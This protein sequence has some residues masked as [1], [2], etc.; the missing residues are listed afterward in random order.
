MRLYWKISFFVLIFCITN[1]NLTEKQNKETYK[2]NPQFEL[3]EKI[4]FKLDGRQN[5]YQNAILNNWLLGLP[6]RNPYMLNMFEERN[7]QKNYNLLPWSGE[8]AGKYLTGA[9][10]I[11][12]LTQSNELKKEL[13]SLVNRLGVLQTT[14]GYLGPW[15]K[16][17]ELTGR[18]PADDTKQSKSKHFKNTWDSWNHYHLM[19]GLL[20]YNRLF[21]DE[22]S[23]E[24]CRKIGDRLCTEF[25]DQPDNLIQTEK[26][27]WGYGNMEFNLTAAHALCIL[28][29]TVGDNKYLKLAK[30]MVDE[31]FLRYGDYVNRAMEGKNFFETEW[32]DG[33]RWERL[34]AIMA[35]AEL[36]W[37]TGDKTY[38]KA[39]EQ[40]W[41]SIAEHDIHNTGAFSTHE[42]ATGN[43]YEDGP[44][45]TCCTVAWQALS[46]EMLKMTGNS[47][48]ADMLEL[49][50]FN[51]AYG[52]WDISGSWN[53][54]HT[55]SF[56]KRVPSTVD[57]AFQIRKGTEE[58]NCCSA[59]AP[60]SIGILADWALM[61]NGRGFILNWYGKGEINV[62]A[63]KI[64][65]KFIQNTDYPKDGNIMI[66]VDPKKKVF[67]SLQLR[68]PFWSR[69]NK[70]IV[71]GEEIS[72][73]SSGSYLKLDRTWNPGDKI[74]V[75]L[76][77][78][79]HFWPGENQ[80]KG[81]GSVYHGPILLAWKKPDEPDIKEVSEWDDRNQPVISFQS[82]KVGSKLIGE[83]E[84]ERLSLIFDQYPDGGQSQV[85]IDDE[86]Y[87]VIDHF[88]PQVKFLQEWKSPKLKSGKHKFRIKILPDKNLKSKDNWVRLREIRLNS[89]PIVDACTFQPKVAS[90]NPKRV[91]WLFFVA[92]DIEGQNI[93]LVDF[94][95]AGKNNHYYYTWLPIQGYMLHKTGNQT[96]FHK[97][98]N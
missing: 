2:I 11:Y 49:A 68:I 66:H 26:T 24:I 9:A 23:L 63:G 35:L 72:K 75:N 84:G 20:E 30:Q 98:C 41:W 47:I 32:R 90:F 19:I 31:G 95:S 88:S 87:E 79:P 44:V 60:R 50:Q 8:F 6:E 45:E 71:N 76:D 29:R 33:N 39:F 37:I 91:P 67:F 86:D 51:S 92:K 80:Y 69:L 3:P 46:V 85:F 34:H 27:G 17:F 12:R 4:V 62:N 52:S 59:N 1:C 14:T 93:E 13:D 36:Y 58:L 21:G 73:V 77:M 7:K 40:I 96:L 97:V 55:G 15:P 56:G 38:H 18:M 16:E 83:F 65:V 78:R 5:I 64:P 94:D 28:Y 10:S 25:L 53:T 43:P 82:N 48:V 57:I 89:L 22:V 74:I 42:K 54:Y 61:R 81:Y 70:V